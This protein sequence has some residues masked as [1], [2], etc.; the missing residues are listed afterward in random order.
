MELIEARDL[1]IGPSGRVLARGVALSLKAGEILAVLGPNGAGKTT[2]F[3]TL[4]GL[5]PPHAGAVRL[6]G[7]DAARL[8][9]AQIATSTF[10]SENTV[11]A[12]MRTLYRK[13]GANSRDEALRRARIFGL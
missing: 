3:R 11:K 10:R 6:A 1:A 8:T 5:I 9:R 12:Q 13:L 4:L 7:A 2:L